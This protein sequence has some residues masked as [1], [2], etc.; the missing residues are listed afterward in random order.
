MNTYY[1]DF[2]LNNGK[3]IETFLETTFDDD[4]LLSQIANS[5]GKYLRTQ[6]R[7]NGNIMA[8]KFDEIACFEIKEK[9]ESR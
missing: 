4:T 1:I 9:G 8:I 3:K 2:Y 6:T 5:R 7:E